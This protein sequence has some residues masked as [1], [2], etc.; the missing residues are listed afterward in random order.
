MPSDTLHI[1]RASFSVEE[2]WAIP[3]GCPTIQ[4]LRATDGG[5]PR[6]STS[7]SVYYDDRYLNVLFSASDDHTVATMERHDD[8]LYEE[9]VVEMFLAPERLTEYFEL[10]VSPLG[11]TFDARIESPDGVR[12]TM[13]ADVA[14][15]CTGFRAGLRRLTEANGDVSVDTLIR[16]PFSGLGRLTPKSGEA[17][18]GNFFRIDRHPDHGDEY[19]AWQPTMKN[20]ADFH[21]AAV[22]GALI[23]LE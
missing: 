10:E 5:M 20:P 22:F 8:P 18:R 19:S 15:E 3:V 1:R 23:F 11:T 7:V 17:W 4:L 21:V 14:W 13:R 6:L 12:Q 9:D 16:V 2:P